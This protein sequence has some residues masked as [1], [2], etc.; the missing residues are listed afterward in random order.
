MQIDFPRAKLE[1]YRQTLRKQEKELQFLDNKIYKILPEEA[2]E[3]EVAATLDFE[4]TI[5][6]T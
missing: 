1:S 2:I 3:N 5:N 6:E 4:G